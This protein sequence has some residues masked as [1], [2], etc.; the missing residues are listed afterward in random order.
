MG[1]V[2]IAEDERDLREEL[3]TVLTA[4]GLEVLEASDRAEALRLIQECECLDQVLTGIN[5][6]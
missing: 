3:S 4:R 6:P 2:L 5:M 1:R